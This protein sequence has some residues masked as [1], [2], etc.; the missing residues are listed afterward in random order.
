MQNDY[1]SIGKIVKKKLDLG[2]LGKNR[3]PPRPLALTSHLW[4]PPVMETHH[5]VMETHNPLIETHNSLIETHNH[6]WKS[7][8]QVCI[9]IRKKRHCNKMQQGVL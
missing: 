3:S 4:K 9:E 7:Y 8:F 1:N 6:L 5:H 2:A